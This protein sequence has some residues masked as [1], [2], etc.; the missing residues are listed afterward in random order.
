MGADAA[1][2]VVGICGDGAE[3][4]KVDIIETR[5]RVKAVGFNGGGTLDFE[6]MV[7]ADVEVGGK[8]VKIMVE[9][10]LVNNNGGG[11]A[12]AI[13]GARPNSH[14]KLTRLSS[15]LA[16]MSAAKA[17][18][19]PFSASSTRVRRQ[20]VQCLCNAFAMPSQFFRNT[21]A[22][23][24]RCLRNAFAMPSQCLRNVFARPLP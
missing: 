2:V 13:P 19:W 15:V 20:W 18:A 6:V 22:I 16:G 12:G 10:S 1:S 21:F 14:A 17:Q 23:P 4:R 3:V 7:A 24:S 11:E 5:L 9:A 8:G